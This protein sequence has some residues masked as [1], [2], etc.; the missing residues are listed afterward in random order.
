[1]KKITTNFLRENPIGTAC[2]SV[3]NTALSTDEAIDF[4]DSFFGGEIFVNDDCDEVCEIHSKI[5]KYL[6]RKDL[7]TL[8]DGDDLKDYIEE[9]EEDFGKLSKNDLV[10]TVFEYLVSEIGNGSARYESDYLDDDGM[11]FFEVE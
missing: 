2:G 11:L 7:S 10:G 9:Y 5:H 1:M 6:T 3:G 4:I 8:C